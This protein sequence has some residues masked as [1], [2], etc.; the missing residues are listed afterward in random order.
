[1]RV[2]HQTEIALKLHLFR[3]LFGLLIVALMFVGCGMN[4]GKKTERNGCELH[5]KKPV[6]KSQ[7]KKLLKYLDEQQ[8]C[9][10][11]RKTMQIR[12]KGSTYEFRMVVKKGMEKDEAYLKTAKLFAKQLSANV[13]KNATVD[14]HMCDEKLKTLRVVVAAP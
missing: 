14:L 1:M 12:K 10:G 7:A 8:F 3:R 2:H 13:F 9:D 11:N 6:K 5:R 4:L